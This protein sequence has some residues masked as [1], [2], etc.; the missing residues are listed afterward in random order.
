[1]YCC[2]SKRT[3]PCESYPLLCDSNPRGGLGG[4]FPRGGGNGRCPER[5]F[6]VGSPS[7]VNLLDVAREGDGGTPPGGVNPRCSMVYVLCFHLLC[8]VSPPSENNN[9][10]VCGCPCQPFGSST[11]NKHRKEGRRMIQQTKVQN[12]STVV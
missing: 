7:N 1:M 9:A 10:D 4:S 11:T 8:F 6:F 12:M 2:T 5:L 3:S